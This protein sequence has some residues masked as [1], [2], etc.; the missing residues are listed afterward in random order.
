[1]RDNGAEQALAFEMLD[2]TLSPAHKAL[3]FP[4]LDPKLDRGKRLGLLKQHHAATAMTCDERLQE[5]IEHSAQTWVR[6]CAIYAAGL[7]RV[8]GMIPLIESTLVDRHPVVRETAEWSLYTL[9]PDRFHQFADAL[10]AD[11]D[12]QVARMAASL[13]EAS[14]SSS[15]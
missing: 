3:S 14:S 10:L 6:A 1:M 5:L 2:V 15:D 11:Q 7:R 12:R 13:V 4:L 9:A 8:D